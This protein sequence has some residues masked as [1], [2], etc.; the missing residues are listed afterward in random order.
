MNWE[1]HTITPHRKLMR[2]FSIDTYKH[3]PSVV[4][5]ERVRE[6]TQELSLCRSLSFSLLIYIYIVVLLQHKALP[7]R[8]LWAWMKEMGCPEPEDLRMHNSKSDLACAF[9]SYETEEQANQCLVCH[10]R[11][12]TDLGPTWIKVGS[13]AISLLRCFSMSRRGVQESEGGTAYIHTHISIYF[14]CRN[15]PTDGCSQLVLRAAS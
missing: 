12:N 3:Q 1:P 9:L 11:V 8:D 6:G 2:T 7:G 5:S 14:F 13:F 15:L 4:E 10:G